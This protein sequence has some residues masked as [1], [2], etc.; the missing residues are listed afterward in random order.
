VGK[1]SQSILLDVLRYVPALCWMGV[2]FGMS[3]IPGSNVPG[4]FSTVAHFIEY[5]IFGALL[6]YPLRRG[7]PVGEG[8]AVSVL[9]ASIYALSDEIHQSFVPMR[10]PD[11]ADWGMDTLGALVGVVAFVLLAEAIRKHRDAGLSPGA[12]RH[13]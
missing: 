13:R 9:F 1:R 8:A 7:R 12:A 5:A 6:A 10:T 4:R 2:I 11:V 3:S